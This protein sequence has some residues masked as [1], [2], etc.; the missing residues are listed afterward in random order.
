MSRK[1]IPLCNTKSP[2][3]HFTSLAAK[4]DRI[5]TRDVSEIFRRRCGDRFSAHSTR[6]GAAQDAKA[7]GA[8][9]GAIPQA[10]GWKS[11]R[12]VSRYTEKLAARE[13]AAA[14]LAQV[15]GR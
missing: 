12:M 2:E 6:V 15:Q 5:G 8:S 13:S 3:A 9:T 1:N 11:E 10:G 14:M 4:N 7:A